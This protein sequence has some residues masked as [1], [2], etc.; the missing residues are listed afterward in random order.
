MGEKINVEETLK[1]LKKEKVE[2]FISDKLTGAEFLDT[3]KGMISAW[4]EEAINLGYEIGE[5]HGMGKANPEALGRIIDSFSTALGVGG[6]NEGDEHLKK[7]IYS[8]RGIIRW[9]AMAIS[10]YESLTDELVSKHIPLKPSFYECMGL[11]SS[12]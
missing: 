5:E 4:L 9:L 8:Q 2:K 1:N 11:G 10:N 7:I 6:S 3:Q 12:R